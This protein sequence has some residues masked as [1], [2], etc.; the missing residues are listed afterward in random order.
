MSKVIVKQKENEEEVPVEIIAQSI[1]KLS[2]AFSKMKKSGLSRYCQ[3]VLLSD[4]SGVGRPDVRKI[5]DSMENFE[6]MYL[7]KK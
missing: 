1:Q 3:V 7:A 5:L 2:E 6:K 4:A